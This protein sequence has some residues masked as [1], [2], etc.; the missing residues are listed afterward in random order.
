MATMTVRNLPDDVHRRIRLY[1]AEHGI[2][3]EAAA[4]RILDE[5]TRPADR[6][7]DIVMA[8]ARARQ[9]NFPDT[10][11]DHTPIAPADFS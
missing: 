11:R 3:A 10:P 6:L 8:F 1:A 2:S 4:R 5:G 7:G 9:A